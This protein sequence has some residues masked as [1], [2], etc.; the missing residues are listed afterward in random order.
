MRAAFGRHESPKLLQ[1]VGSHVS[2]KE[3]EPIRGNCAN[4][5]PLF[6]PQTCWL[7]GEQECLLLHPTII[8]SDNTISYAKLQ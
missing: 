2:G 5:N 3:L 6:I 8:L 4:K 7:Y 1:R